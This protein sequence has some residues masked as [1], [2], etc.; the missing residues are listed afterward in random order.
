MCRGRESRPGFGHATHSLAPESTGL[1]PGTQ[2]CLCKRGHLAFMPLLSLLQGANDSPCLRRRWPSTP[3][4]VRPPLLLLCLKGLP[5]ACEP[6]PSCPGDIPP[7]R[8]PGT[9]RAL[10]PAS[11]YR[12][13][14]PA[15]APSLPGVLAPSWFPFNCHTLV[16]SD[17]Y[18]RQGIRAVP[19]LRCALL[20]WPHDSLG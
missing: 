18:F 11:G 12:T 5:C 13:T 7:D 15:R 9:A 3:A 8:A 16:F 19:F 20:G 6:S 1:V 17:S 10:A 4:L 14:F 2:Q